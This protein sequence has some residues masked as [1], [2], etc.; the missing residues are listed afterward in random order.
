MQH[1]IDSWSSAGR[2]QEQL[3]N[4]PISAIRPKWVWRPD[5]VE[6]AVPLITQREFCELYN[7]T[8]HLFIGDSITEQT[9]ISTHHVAL[10]LGFQANSILETV[11]PLARSDKTVFPFS[12]GCDGFTIPACGATFIYVRND[13]LDIGATERVHY[14]QWN[15]WTQPV[16]DIMRVFEPS[17][18]VLNRGAHY[19][20]DHKYAAGL[21][22]AVARVREALPS[23]HVI[24][25]NTPQGHFW[26]CSAYYAEPL[27]ELPPHWGEGLPWGGD[28]FPRQNGIMKALAAELG[29]VMLDYAG[30]TRFR[31]D[32]HYSATDCLHYSYERAEAGLTVPIFWV[33]LNFAAAL[34]LKSASA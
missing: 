1:T 7:G 22:Y 8:T 27:T 30:P 3:Y 32:H 24:L 33:Q 34:L 18:V 12:D 31:P 10:D 11:K 4:L 19:D 29:V 5:A 6:A 25:R 9:F 16:Q 23:A 26:N 21:R 13:H 14:R 20:V 28:E 15:V 17:H 2:W